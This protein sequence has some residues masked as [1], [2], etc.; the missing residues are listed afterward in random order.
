MPQDWIAVSATVIVCAYYLLVWLVFRRPRGLRTV[1]PLYEAPRQLSPAMLRYIWKERF[2][3]RTFWAGVL[4]LVAKDLATLHCEGGAAL[5]QATPHTDRPGK[6]PSEEQVLL[7]K[8]VQVHQ[9]KG[10][11]IDMLSAK[12]ASAVQDMAKSLRRDAL[13]LWFT[14]NRP[15]GIGGAILSVA[16]L[17][18]VA[19][20]H[21]KEQWEALILG[22]AVM[23]PGAF[24]LFFA[25]LRV[26][27]LLKALRQNFDWAVLRREILLLTMLVPCLAAIVLGEVVVG[28]TF[29]REAVAATLF[30]AVLNVSCVRI[31]TP[32]E[33]GNKVLTEIEGFRLFLKSVERLP[34]QRTDEP[35]D[36]A[37]SYEKYLPYAVALEVEQ[38]WG[39]RLLALTS[40]YH[41]NAGLP[42]AEAFY[43]GM[44]N[45]KPLEIV[46]K[47]DAPRSR[48]L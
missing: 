16:A 34:M 9:R 12:T 29:G 6:L 38:A 31:Q 7:S 41:E 3:D 43:L 33:E 39:D 24:Y 40:T 21:N 10:S 18:L 8:L 37:G 48:A 30:L 44:C 47:P 46:Y 5:L 25:S 28:G 23:A 22:L 42:G 17:L 13:G 14:E 4:N 45:G 15:I 27:D 32:T 36:H 20:P 1:V 2:D 11:P 26:W 35:A 19:S